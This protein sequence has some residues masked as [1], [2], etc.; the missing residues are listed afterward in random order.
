MFRRSGHI[1]SIGDPQE[2]PGHTGETLSLCWLGNTYIPLKELD[3]VAVEKKVWASL[4]R[5][6]PKTPDKWWKIDGWI[7][8]WVNETDFKMKA[9]SKASEEDF[10]TGIKF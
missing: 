4:L 2:E 7:D 8:G 9:K 5:L 1:P 6:L 3:K 10:M